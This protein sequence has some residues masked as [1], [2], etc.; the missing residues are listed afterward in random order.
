MK[1]GVVTLR[2]IELAGF[3][4]F[5]KRTKIEFGN[6]LVAIVG[7]NGSGKSNIADAIRWVFGEQKSKSLRS[8]KAEDLIYHGGKG[9]S[10]A[11]MA[12]VVITLDNSAGKIP[13]GLKEIEITRRLYRSGESNY[14]LNGKKVS[15]SSIREILASSGFGVGTYT[16]IGQGMIER[17][18][19]A[20]GI[21]RKKLFEEASGIKQFEIKLSQTKKRL[22]QTLQNLK[23]ID[24]LISELQP[25]LKTLEHQSGLLEKRQGML[26]DLSSLRLAYITQT[27]NS[28]SAQKSKI[29]SAIAELEGQDRA[30]TNEL[31]VLEASRKDSGTSESAI[32]AEQINQQLGKL[33][34]ENQKVDQAIAQTNLDIQDASARTEES[35]KSVR[36]IKQTIMEYSNS[37]ASHNKSHKSLQASVTKYD[38]KISLIDSKIKDQTKILDQTKRELNKTQKTEYLRHSLGLIDILQDSINK[39]RPAQELTLVFYKLRRSIKH[40]IND[41]SAE[42]ALQVGRVQNVIARLLDEREQQVES[43][44][45]EVIKLRASEMDSAAISNKITQLEKELKAVLATNAALKDPKNQKTMELKLKELEKTKAGVLNQMED[46]RIQLV[47]IASQGQQENNS[48]YF[49]KHEDITSKQVSVKYQ[50]QTQSEALTKL[51][52][53]LSGVMSLKKSW[54]PNGT[55]NIPSYSKKVE[56]SDIDSLNAQLSLLQQINPAVQKGAKEAMERMGFLQAQSSDLN[57]ALA[58]LQKLSDNTTS[59][60]QSVFQKGFN[61]INQNFSKSF[62]E[63]FGGGKAELSLSEHSDGFGIDIIVQL[64]NKQLQPMSSLSGGEKALASVALLSAI[65][66]SNPSPFIVLDE[67]DAALDESNTKKFAEVIAQIT[68][69]SQVLVVT[70]NH[71]TM[72]AASELLGVTTSGNNDS[73]IIRVRLDSLPVGS[74]TN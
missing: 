49:S 67:V 35:T 28:V 19:L 33:E 55:K 4:S 44:T 12:E 46:M 53:E 73:H 10:Q 51:E 8:D 47:D 57:R 30:L 52:S 14:L 43:Q 54:F 17:L 58:D 42:L 1:S 34:L 9:K 56:L 64:P 22:D 65:L 61:R 29:N 48:E 37:I 68:K 3:K 25:Q 70:H 41:N 45:A 2:S 31:T 27:S 72:A 23:Q 74:L 39:G 59:K 69:H 24:D 50:L 16:V 11:S 13:L 20:D 18:I 62:V 60:M 15:L 6:G 38:N 66:A 63:L 32:V 36:R 5:A 40:S 26:K 21:E 71:E 7:P